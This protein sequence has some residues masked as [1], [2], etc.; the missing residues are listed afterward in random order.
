MYRRCF[1]FHSVFRTVWNGTLENPHTVV[2]DHSGLQYDFIH[3]S[4][5]LQSAWRGRE[6]HDHGRTFPGK[7][8]LVFNDHDGVLRCIRAGG[9]P[10]GINVC[11]A[12]TWNHQNDR[13]SGGTYGILYFNGNFPLDLWKI[14]RQIRSGSVYEIKYAALHWLLSAD[15]IC[16]GSGG[17]TLVG[18]VS[19]VFSNN[20]RVGIGASILFPVLL[21]AGLVLVSSKR[22]EKCQIIF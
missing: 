10:V 1:I 2:G 19:S 4:A 18:F 6:G 22:N 8:I 20:L 11:G 5:N 21:L 3:K 15:R 13:W 7:S 12:G 17:P 9:E 16:A 14:W